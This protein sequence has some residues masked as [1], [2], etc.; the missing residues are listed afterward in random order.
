MTQTQ[1]LV[2]SWVHSHEEDH[3]GIR[4]YR[5]STTELPPSRG[6]DSVTL[7]EDGTAVA[8]LPGPADA[9]VTTEDGT[10]RLEGDVLNVDCPGW[11]GT[12]EIVAADGTVLELRHQ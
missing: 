2:G 3:D 11:T 4:V 8:G 6:R 1:F 10:W 12:Y 5:P 7:R 9:G